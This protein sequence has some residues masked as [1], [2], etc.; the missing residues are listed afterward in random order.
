MSEKIV[1]EFSYTNRADTTTCTLIRRETPET[2]TGITWVV[3]ITHNEST[4]P[5]EKFDHLSI[6]EM[7]F[8]NYV[9]YALNSNTMFYT[10]SA[11]R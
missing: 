8:K 6:A 7:A 9:L 1:K 2:E 10:Y 4:K 11:G 3:S 5:D